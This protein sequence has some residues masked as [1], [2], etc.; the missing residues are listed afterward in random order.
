[1]EEAIAS[2]Q[3]VVVFSQYLYML[4]IIELY[5]K[6]KGIGYAQIRGDTIDRRSE[7]ARF[8]ENPTCKVFIGS[9]QAAGV[10]IDLTAGSVVIMYD[11]WWNQAKENQA[12]D[13][14]HRIGQKWAVQVFKLITKGTIEEKIDAMISKKGRL[15]EKIITADEQATLK[16]FS[17]CRTH[18]TLLL[19]ID[20]GRLN[21]RRRLLFG[22]EQ[23]CLCG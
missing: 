19:P 14:V 23:E 1:M 9:L 21:R 8:Q 5:L 20:N 7:M 6:E 13:R 17:L 15:M 3:K 16:E 11:R 2:E 4:D 10:G 22:D 12:I 18:R